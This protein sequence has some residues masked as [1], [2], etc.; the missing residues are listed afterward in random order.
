MNPG[1]LDEIQ[2][3]DQKLRTLISDSRLVG[4]VYHMGYDECVVLSNDKWKEKADG[5]PK[6]SF[7]LATAADWENPD[8]FE[9]EDAYAILLRVKEPAKLS[10]E[11]ELMEIR[12]EAMRKKI[13][14]S[15]EEIDDDK[16]IV[17]VLTKNEIQFSG[18]RAKIL[19]TFYQEGDQIKFG[20]DVST[21]YSAA[22]YKVY[23][24]DDQALS[25]IASYPLP[26]S[27][28]DSVRLGR[29]R[30]TATERQG[31]PT[32]EVRLNVDDFIGNKTGVFGMTRSGKSNTMKIIA[33]A[34]FE[35][36]NRNDEDIGQLLFD[37]AGE[38][39]NP[40][41]QD[42]IAL[43]ELGP[44]HVTV[45]KWGANTDSEGVKTLQ[46]NFFDQ[47][48]TEEVWNLIRN[49]ISKDADY[50]KEFKSTEIFNPENISDNIA[51]KKKM[52]R[53]LSA[54]YAVL[55]KAEFDPEGLNI[56]TPVKSDVLDLVEEEQGEEFESSWGGG[57]LTLH[58]D[59]ILSFW[60]VVAEEIGENGVVDDWLDEGT[61]AILQ[62]LN[63]STGTGYRILRQFK[64]FHDT[65]AEGNYRED[66]YSDLED[67]KIV[68]IDMSRGTEEVVI[69]TSDRIVSKVMDKA[70]EK[71]TS[72]QELD[73]IQI[74]IEEAHRQFDPDELERAEDFDPYV[75]LAKEA[76]KYNI[77]LIYSTQEVTGVDERILANTAN[78][79]SMH[80]N[81]DEETRKLGRYY[82]FEDF[83]R[84]IKE[85]QETGFARIK[86]KSSKF[87]I[88]VQIDKF[89]RD[90][91]NEALTGGE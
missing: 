2:L 68:I 40:N 75:R 37:P 64:P 12:E 28:K 46:L 87:I 69:K 24:P 33:T 91:V 35:H 19:G 54:L 73:D 26:E 79:V 47:E 3:Q 20:N 13:T 1:F 30:Y 63:I 23:K 43:K 82:N 57:G 86:P 76:A 39:A 50:I 34:I 85:V 38:Y 67:G 45:Y 18:I 32:S 55:K 74:Y 44:E 53:R 84:G 27:G 41:D 77:G 17:D 31:F 5:I 59:N 15:S 56:D 65:E 61:K 10:N 78:W 25:Y 16:T 80:L 22:Q 9:E 88:P 14:D 89:D 11:D 6:N 48:Q 42:E 83:E 70:L 8:E 81:N 49:L 90:R 62:M 7:L 4:G 72:N 36:A 21:F 51:Y 66:I 58:R 29:V 60:E 71:F 52:Q